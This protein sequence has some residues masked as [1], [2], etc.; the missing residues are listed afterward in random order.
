MTATYIAVTT[1]DAIEAFARGNAHHLKQKDNC[2]SHDR[3]VQSGNRQHVNHSGTRI[4]V[5]HIG[6]NLM[7]I[8]DEQ[9]LRHRC[10][11]AKQIVYRARSA[12]SCYL[13]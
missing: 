3:D 12:R 9:S 4:L 8:S 10:I 13:E 5:P 11:T 2:F 7:L 6:G 1:I